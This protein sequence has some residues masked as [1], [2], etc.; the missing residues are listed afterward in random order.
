MIRIMVVDDQAVIRR[1]LKRRLE[2]EMDLSIVGEARDGAEALT[3]AARLKPDVIIMNIQMPTM[4]GIAATSALQGQ[5]PDSAVL[6]LSIHDDSVT[7]ARA[8]SAGAVAFLTKQ[9]VAQ[10]IQ[11]IRQVA[12]P[13]PQAP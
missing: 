7:R 8:H 1:E 4:D 5:A 6:I 9:G 13:N 2:L 12:S 3:Q 10:L 11:Q